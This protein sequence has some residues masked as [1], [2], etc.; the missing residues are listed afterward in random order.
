MICSLIFVTHH[1]YTNIFCNTRG[2]CVIVR[3]LINPHS[4]IERVGVGWEKITHKGDTRL[5]WLKQTE[6]HQNQTNRS[7]VIDKNVSDF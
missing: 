5:T 2:T 3:C 4:Y 6:P 7:Q 1:M